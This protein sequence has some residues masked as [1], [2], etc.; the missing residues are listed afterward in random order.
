MEELP[1]STNRSTFTPHHSPPIVK[2]TA[3]H[4]EGFPT[5][6]GDERHCNFVSHYKDTFQGAWSR[7]A[8]PVD[9]HSSSVIMGDPVKIVE[10][11]TTH[12][13]SF[14]RPTACRPGVVKESVKLH[15]GNFSKT[16]WSSTSKE[17]YCYHKLGAP[18]VL[19]RKNKNSS[20]LPRGDTD[21][22][23]NRERMSVTTNRVSFT[24]PPPAERLVY[25]PGSD[26][27]TKSN[28]Q[29]SPALTSGLYYTTT[30]KHHYGKKEG[31]PA[32][33]AIQLHSNILSGP[34]PVPTL[35]T[36]QADFL[37]LRACKQTPCLSLQQSN[38]RFPLAGPRFSTTHSEDYTSKPLIVQQPGRS[39]FLSHCVVK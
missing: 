31:E 5:I 14:S 21:T 22:I 17:A 10:R 4:L 9:K 26:L 12:S 2:A 38:I 27:M 30:A 3:K 33:P 1:E 7:A 25:V 28:V 32:R 29:F 20:S 37:P 36:T 13:A 15:L 23:R 34:E 19:T 24:D 35:S 39:H 8:Q 11:E 18:V 16:S 6:K